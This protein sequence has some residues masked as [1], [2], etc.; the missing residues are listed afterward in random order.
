MDYSKTKFS[1]HRVVLVADLLAQASN[2]AAA[3]A[4]ARRDL[5][6]TDDATLQNLGSA[7]ESLGLTFQVYSGPDELAK[8]ADLHVND[9]VLSIYGG[10]ESR[11]RMALVPAVCESFG[12]RFIGPDV[13]GRI[14]AQDKEITKR[15]ALEV[16]LLTPRWRIVRFKKDI[17]LARDLLAP[18]VVK[19][20]MEGSSIG[21]SQR[22]L[23]TRDE[24]IP[25]MIDEILTTFDQ[26]ALVEEFVSGREVAY[27][28]IQNGDDDFW[29]FSEVVIGADPDFF[30]QRLFD[31]EEKMYPS[32]T[33]S[34]RNID[35]ELS[36]EDHAAIKAL[37]RTFGTYGYCRVDGRLAN[38]RFNFLE[39]TPD[40]WIAPRGQFARG[41][42]EKGWTYEAVIRAVLCSTC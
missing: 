35:S 5:E 25:E 28:S 13:Y 31:A 4:H 20:L 10:K 33:R 11:N 27:C 42:T 30:N 34:V 19:P 39:L 14:I 21:I 3:P 24:A 41:F 22:N 38:G 23:V 2:E 26:P 15:L 32:K 6:K 37:L 7:F 1:F 12:L 8:N 18:V 29:C 40:A 9:I 17:Q 16:G 36:Q